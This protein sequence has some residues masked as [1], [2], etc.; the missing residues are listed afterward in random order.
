SPNNLARSPW[1]VCSV[2][3]WTGHQD[4]SSITD[5]EPRA[6]VGR[7]AAFLILCTHYLDPVQQI[8]AREG[9]PPDY[10]RFSSVARHNG[11]WD[12]GRASSLWSR[13]CR[14]RMPA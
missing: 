1:N 4:L 9:T 8:A 6:D 3:R 2:V 5:D 14:S 12:R 7:A 10:V 11:R 13:H